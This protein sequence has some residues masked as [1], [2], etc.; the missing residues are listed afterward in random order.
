MAARVEALA[1]TRRNLCQLL[2][3]RVTGSLPTS[4]SQLLQLHERSGASRRGTRNRRVI[5][6]GDTDRKLL[7]ETIEADRYPLLTG[8]PP[9]RVGIPRGATEH[10]RFAGGGIDTL[11]SAGD[12][13]VL[14]G[15]D[16]LSAAVQRAAP[17]EFVGWCRSHDYDDK[18]LA[19]PHHISHL[20][21]RVRRPL[22]RIF[23][24]VG[25]IGTPGSRA[26]PVWHYFYRDGDRTGERRSSQ[27]Q[28]SGAALCKSVRPLSW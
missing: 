17:D 27:P 5:R 15:G 24:Y 11:V 28:M 25:W 7:V 4:V 18:R 8:W 14:S 13:L 3:M 20:S 2:C 26:R 6:S 12:V 22:A 19:T 23:G 16:T 10:A 9:Y 21:Y 1:R